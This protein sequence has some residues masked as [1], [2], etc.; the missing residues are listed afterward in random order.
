[1]GGV[2]PEAGR[3]V[4]RSRKGEVARR[5]GGGKKVAGRESLNPSQGGIVGGCRGVIPLQARVPPDGRGRCEA[6][7]EGDPR[8]AIGLNVAG[9][10]SGAPLSR[11][12]ARIRGQG[13]DLMRENAVLA[14]P[15]GS[16]GATALVVRRGFGLGECGSAAGDFFDDLGGGLVPDEGLGV[17]VP[18]LGPG[19]DGSDEIVDTGEDAAA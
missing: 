13:S 18:M 8:L 7:G 1:M 14:W 17:V 2:P 15:V 6:S 16:E 11:F 12:R 9:R 19:F 10:G 3:G 4:R 5:A